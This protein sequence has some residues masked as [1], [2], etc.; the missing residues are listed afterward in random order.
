V[1]RRGGCLVDIPHLDILVGELALLAFV[2]TRAAS[3]LAVDEALAVTSELELGDLD[4]RGVDGDLHLHA[5]GLVLDDALN[6]D[7]ITL[8]VDSHHLSGGLLLVLSTHNLHLIVLAD[9]ERSHAVLLAQLL[10][11]GSAHDHTALA[12][13]SSEMS[14]AL[15]SAGRAD[16]L[17]VLHW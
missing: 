7:A 17:V 14:L 8:A 3:P 5:V 11:E 1:W 15:L 16:V 2:K 12:G 13:G 9:G 10:A 4:I 6:M